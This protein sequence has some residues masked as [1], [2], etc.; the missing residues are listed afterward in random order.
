MENIIKKLPESR[1]K[2]IGYKING[3][4]DKLHEEAWLKGLDE[5]IVE[6]GKINVLV[7]FDGKASW[8]LTAGIED[9]RWVFSNYKSMGKFAVVS[10]TAFWKWF[11]ALDRPFAKLVGIEERFFEEDKIEDAWKWLKEEL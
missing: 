8:D 6:H 2:T 4:I 9:M 7:W 5:L 10:N 11:T 1:G 3:K